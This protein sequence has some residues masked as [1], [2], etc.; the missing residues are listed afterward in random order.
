MFPAKLDEKGRL[1][2]PTK[3][4]EYLDALR[5][6]RLFVTSLDRTE[7][8]IYTLSV[9]RENEK[10]L[11]REAA[12]D[13]AFIAADL[14]AESEMDSQGRILIPAKLRAELGIENSTVR[15]WANSGHVRVLSDANYQAKKQQSAATA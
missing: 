9:W 14:G 4:Q 11:A 12:D 10:R 5:E 8:R 2:A 13:V 3:I 15:L 6:K 1:K 7:T